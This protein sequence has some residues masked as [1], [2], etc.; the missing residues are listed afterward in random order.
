MEHSAQK[1]FDEQYITTTEIMKLVGV[2]RTAIYE[3]RLTGKLPEPID[4]QGKIFA[5]ERKKIQGYLSAWKAVLETRR[6][7]A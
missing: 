2:T 6:G 4:I 5:W 7:K 1:H 3:A